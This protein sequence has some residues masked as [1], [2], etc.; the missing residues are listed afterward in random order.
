[1]LEPTPLNDL[2]TLRNDADWNDA[3]FSRTKAYVCSLFAEAAYWHIPEFELDNG[4]R[5][6]V[7][8]CQAYR[9]LVRRNVWGDEAATLLL[10]NADMEPPIVVFRR[11]AVVVAFIV[12]DVVF[13]AI[14]GTAHLYD[15]LINLDARRIAIGP[16]AVNVR[17]HRGFF[18]ALASALEEV[19]VELRRHAGPDTPIYVAGHSLGGALAAIMH[20]IWSINVPVR[21]SQQGVAEARMTT[22]RAAYTFGMPRYGNFAAVRHL[23][24]PHHV[25]RD[26]DFVP[27]V[28]PRWL[29][30]DE[31]F[32]EYR[33]DGDCL[34][35]V[36]HRSSMAQIRW[37][38]YLLTGIGLRAHSMERYR[39]SLQPE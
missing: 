38:F 18:R 13:I 33:T 12:Q 20:A 32:V 36:L 11:Y 29:G 3:S 7:V 35:R 9:E 5:F 24:T 37:L 39:L 6:K 19:S 25:Y 16:D 22:T 26:R 23:A 28:P 4:G 30:F 15:W 10:K 17:L 31:P 2:W 21:S 1:M 8:P 27:R 14:R 34:E